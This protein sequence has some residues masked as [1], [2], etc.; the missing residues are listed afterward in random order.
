[1]YIIMYMHITE[2]LRNHPY[3][4]QGATVNYPFPKSGPGPMRDCVDLR[5][6]FIPT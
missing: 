1:M 5:G 2:Y 6:R 4:T 3:F